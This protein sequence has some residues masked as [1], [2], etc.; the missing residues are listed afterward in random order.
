MRHI[1]TR[2]DTVTAIEEILNEKLAAICARLDALEAQLL[3]AG[4]APDEVPD[5]N[6]VEV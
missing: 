6:P 3:S 4:P 5:D 1:L 2:E